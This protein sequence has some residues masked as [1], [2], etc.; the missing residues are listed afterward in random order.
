MHSIL[1]N[2]VFE[3]IDSY[4]KRFSKL[5]EQIFEQVISSYEHEDKMLEPVLASRQY[6]GNMLNKLNKPSDG[7]TS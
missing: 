4:Q 3:D 2:L 1:R 5:A 7:A 6:L